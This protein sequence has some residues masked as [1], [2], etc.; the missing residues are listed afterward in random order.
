MLEKSALSRGGA[1][2]EIR[3]DDVWRFT[4]PLRDDGK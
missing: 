3:S 2:G 4:W 1:S